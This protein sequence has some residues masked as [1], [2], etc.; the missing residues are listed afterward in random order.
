VIVIVR[1]LM[2]RAIGVNRP[3]LCADAYRER[4]RANEKQNGSIHFK[5]L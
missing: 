2:A 1:V 4:D 5:R 3:Y